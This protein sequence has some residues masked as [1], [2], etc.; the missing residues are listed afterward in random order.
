MSDLPRGWAWTTLGEMG[1]WHG[2]GTPSKQNPRFW[3]GGT[4]PWL[5]PKDMG[6][7]VLRGTQDHI[8]EAAIAGSSTSLIRADSVVIVVRSGILER[9]VPIALV[10]FETTLNQDMKAVVPYPG[11]DS[12]W[13]LYVLQ[14]QMRVILDSCRKDGTTVASL[15]TAKLQALPIALP[16]LPE[17]RR[18]V[19]VL[20]DQL[21]RLD[22]AATTLASISSRVEGLITALVVDALQAASPGSELPDGWEWRTLDSMSCGS[23]YGTSTKCDAQGQGIGVV[24]IPNIQDG[25]LDLGDMKYAV[26]RGAD[27]TR[28]HLNVGD[29][30]FV[31]TNGSPSLIG[32][33]AVV[34]ENLSIA[35]ASYLIR[36]QLGTSEIADW[37]QLVLTSPGW[38]EQILD[39][40]ASSA[41]QY[42][43]N[44]TFLKS[45]RIPLP[46]ADV[47]AELIQS[48]RDRCSDLARLTESV[49]FAQSRCT[50]LRRSLLRAAF[51]GELVDQDPSDEP[52][53]IVLD[54]IRNESQPRRTG[55]SSIKA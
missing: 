2:G 23:S 20:E 41:G 8:T 14:S 17:Q 6:N 49:R 5:S 28:L 40:A 32:R 11:V 27:L 42:N 52:A 43:L 45:L 16:P 4:I 53:D 26:D 13:L 31:R 25:E 37:V 24:R 36:F 51:N 1:S 29:L 12:R 22:A 30:L 3:E 39:A 35:F 18:I 55:A 50:G 21:S 54:R 33:T 38:R 48:H 10:P 7:S 19:E 34:R 15:D 47:R 9:T 46:P 44:Q